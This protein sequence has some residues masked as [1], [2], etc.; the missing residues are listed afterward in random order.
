MSY[1][2]IAEAEK[3]TFYKPNFRGSGFN[4]LIGRNLPEWR[5]R[6]ENCNFIF[7]KYLFSNYSKEWWNFDFL[8]IIDF[9]SSGLFLR[10]WNSKGRNEKSWFRRYLCY[11]TK[12]ILTLPQ[13]TLW[14]GH[15]YGKNQ[16]GF[17]VLN[18]MNVLLEVS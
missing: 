15:W 3:I 10:H 7:K 18:L 6:T 2:Q 9:E 13:A 11:A 16:S 4:W 14:L 17:Y 5:S 1:S 12:Y 8:L